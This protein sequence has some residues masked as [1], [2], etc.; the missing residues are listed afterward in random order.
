MLLDQATMAKDT[1]RITNLASVIQN[2]TEEINAYLRTNG[3]ALPSFDSSASP[4]FLLPDSLVGAQQRV[5]EACTELQ[6]LLEGPRAHLTQ[7]TSPR[8]RTQLVNLH[9][10]DADRQG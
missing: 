1:S 10:R 6:A 7:I 5:L 2:S 9:N 4:D 8:V 3:K